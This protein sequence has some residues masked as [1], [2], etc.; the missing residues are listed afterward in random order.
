MNREALNQWVNDQLGA[1]NMS[2]SAL[3]K[4]AGIPRGYIS[5]VLSDKRQG[6]LDFYF[7]V[8]QALD[9]VPEMLGVA[10]IV[11]GPDL[12]EMSLLDL[13]KAIRRMSPE[14]RRQVEDYVDFLLSKDDQPAGSQSTA[15]TNP[16]TGDA[17]A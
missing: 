17:S 15:P 9:A 14:K 11:G 5:K 3:E 4:I 7:R 10:G 1:R 13:F 8:A 16:A 2:M 12:Q 6:G